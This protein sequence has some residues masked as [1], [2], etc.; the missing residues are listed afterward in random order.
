MLIGLRREQIRWSV[1][2]VVAFGLVSLWSG[3]TI[4]QKYVVSIPDV[5]G[6]G[7]SL[8]QHNTVQAQR[9]ILE[10]PGLPLERHIHMLSDL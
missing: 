4:S 9:H 6:S 5:Q 8:V 7:L 3:C 10:L 2:F 1:L